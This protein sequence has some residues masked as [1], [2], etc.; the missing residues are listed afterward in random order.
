MNGA[1]SGK[2]NRIAEL[3]RISYSTDDEMTELCWIWFVIDFVD[4]E[5]DELRNFGRFF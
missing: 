2:M 4:G 1:I 5:C 3:S